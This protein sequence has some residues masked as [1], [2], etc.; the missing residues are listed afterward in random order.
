MN[1]TKTRVVTVAEVEQITPQVKRFTLRCAEG[2]RLP[3]WSGGSHIGVTLMDGHQTW[4]NSYS[5]VGRPGETEFYQ[6]AVRREDPARSKGGSVFLH[7]GVQRGDMLEISAPH[8]Y[9]PLARH[10]KKHVLIAGGIGITPFMAQMAVLKSQG[11]SYELHYAFRSRLE[12]AFCDTLCAEHGL[13][14]HFYISDQGHRLVPQLILAAQPLG[15]HLYVCGSHPL[16]AAVT[17]AAAHLGWPKTH[18]H[19]EKFAPPPIQ[20]ASPFTASLPDLGMDIKVGMNETL[21]ES[22][23][24]AGVQIA[25]SC[26]VGLCGTCEMRVLVGEPEHRDRCLSDEERADGKILACVS[27]SQSD[28]LILALAE[29]AP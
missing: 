8:N 5:L 11:Q 2:G 29:A 22:L 28:Y 23:E 27:R 24:S 4:R 14:T 7:E 12:G 10:A 26:R 18:I 16:I 20:N 1:R 17:Q 15:T 19:W 25:S 3:A 9:F 21:L 6:I 13:N